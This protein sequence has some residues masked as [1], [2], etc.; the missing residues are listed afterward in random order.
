MLCHCVGSV[1]TW[2]EPVESSG[3]CCFTI[4]V[5]FNAVQP[6]ESKF[7]CSI[8]WILWYLTELSVLLRGHITSDQNSANTVSF[9]VQSCQLPYLLCIQ[10]TR[11]KSWSEQKEN[12]PSVELQKPYIGS[13]ISGTPEVC[14]L[15]WQHHIIKDLKKILYIH[16]TFAPD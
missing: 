3:F 10:V 11:Q 13:L 2:R 5:L 16:K 12:F 15:L 7:Q 6:H 8:K 14:W 4:A 1:N 9:T